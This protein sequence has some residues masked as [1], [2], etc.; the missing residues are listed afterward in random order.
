[1]PVPLH[2]SAGRCGGEGAGVVSADN[3][4]HCPAC[5]R[6]HEA[7]VAKAHSKADAAYAKA[8]IEEF[9]RLRELA[10]KLA[11]APPEKSMRED[12]DIGIVEG[13]FSIDYRASCECGFSFNYKHE[14]EAKP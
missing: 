5:L 10:T 11:A 3:W 1:V 2:A 8:P 6:K 14:Q 7:K 12:Y 13:W 9:D 4:T